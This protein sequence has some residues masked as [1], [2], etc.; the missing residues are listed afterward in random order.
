MKRIL[1]AVLLLIA[2][3]TT[4]KAQLLPANQCES[5]SACN[6]RPL[7]GGV[8]NNAFSYVTT[9]ASNPIGTCASSTG[10]FAYNSNWMFYKFTCY[11]TGIFNF[12][13]N[14]NDSASDLDWALWDVTVTG[15]GTLTSANVVEC[16]AAG[17]G[18]TGIQTGTTPAA[19]FEPNV[20]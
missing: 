20:T 17:N 11:S 14:A 12:R 4:L 1:S 16:N 18:P 19:N 7:C 10:T 9:P 2:F 13:L 5:Q 8:I 6:A 15:C 3:T